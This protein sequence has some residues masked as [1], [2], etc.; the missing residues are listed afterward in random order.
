M[1]GLFGSPMRADKRTE[2][3]TG[4]RIKAIDIIKEI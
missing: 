3:G 4:R 2:D 1:D